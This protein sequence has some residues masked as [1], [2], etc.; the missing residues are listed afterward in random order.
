MDFV[1][2]ASIGVL[3]L[4]TLIGLG[5]VVGRHLRWKCRK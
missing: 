3:F 2:T 4:F 1:L 5:V